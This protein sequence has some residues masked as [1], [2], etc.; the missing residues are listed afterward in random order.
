MAFANGLRFGWPPRRILAA[1][2]RSL[3]LDTVQSV[4]VTQ[5]FLEALFDLRGV[6]LDVDPCEL[7]AV[8]EQGGDRG[9][10][11]RLLEPG[12]FVQNVY[13]HLRARDGLLHRLSSHRRRLPDISS[14]SRV[15]NPR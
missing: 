8:V 2:G 9:F 12:P 5:E 11:E 10:V 15:N 3:G 13:G 6:T 7:R 1:F 4:T 14:M